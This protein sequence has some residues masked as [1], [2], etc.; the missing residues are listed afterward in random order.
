[1][2]KVAIPRTSEGVGAGTVLSVKEKI[3]SGKPVFEAMVVQG[4]TVKAIFYDLNN[5][6]PT[7]G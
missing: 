1:M 4:N 2:T 7:G 6:E 5:G 3:R